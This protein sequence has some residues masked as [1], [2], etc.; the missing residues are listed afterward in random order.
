MKKMILGATAAA[1]LASPAL[2]APSAEQTVTIN[3]TAPTVCTL[4]A[5]T[6]AN[7][8]GNLNVT[9]STVT[10]TG[11]FDAADATMDAGSVTL[12]FA[13]MCNY[14]HNVSLKSANGYL[15]NTTSNVAP[16]SGTF[17]RRIGYNAA[18]AWANVFRPTA[19]PAV[20]STL[21][22]Q[23]GVAVTSADAA[24]SGANLGTL[25][26]TLRFDGS[27]TTPVVAGN[28]TDS[29]TVQIGADL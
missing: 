13:G 5:P 26:V 10:V 27:G 24:V 4:G 2:A 20:D 21:A 25:N 3:G 14:P 11:L 29:L 7:L 15:Y 6:S 12:R 23:S 17:F 22:G 8:V 1:L 19:I 16:L 18:Y 28:Y 9:G